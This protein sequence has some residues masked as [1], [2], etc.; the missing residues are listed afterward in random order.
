M[1][2]SATAYR[3]MI[4]SPSDV[5][6]AREIAREVVHYW[7]AINSKDEEIVLLPTGWESH[8]APSMEDAPQAVINSQVLDECD[9]LIAI[10]WTR[11]GTPTRAFESGTVEEIERHI[12]LGKPAMIYFSDTPTAPSHAIPAQ[13]EAV[14]RF[15]ESLQP[16]G[17]VHIFK[18]LSSFRVDLLRHLSWTVKNR[19]ATDIRGA[20][21]VLSDRQPAPSLSTWATELLLA[22]VADRNGQITCFRGYGGPKIESNGREF[23]DDNSP[24]IAARWEHAIEELESRDLIR[25]R[26][27]KR[28]SFQV[29]EPG[30]TFAESL[31]AN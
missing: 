10:F 11:L 29:T 27:A 12:G 21:S 20:P 24:R 30:Y 13:I 17:L 1:P 6:D 28:E 25:A 18:D 15:R 23:L 9:L 22:A 8:A 19:L 7:N 4:A 5:I 3:V 16:R 14:H 2:Y 31:D 26:S